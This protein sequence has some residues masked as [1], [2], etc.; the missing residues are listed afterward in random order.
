MAINKTKILALASSIRNTRQELTDPITGVRISRPDPV[1]NMIATCLAELASEVDAIANP[2]PV[3]TLVDAVGTAI[4]PA[5]VTTYS[6]SGG[7]NLIIEWI[8]PDPS[9]IQYF[10][11]R[12]GADYATADKILKTASTRV[13]L[14]PITVGTT[15]YT[16]KSV[17]SSGTE[18]DNA[19]AISVS[20]TAPTAITLTPSVIDNNVLLYW[21]A[22][23][24]FFDIDYYKVERGIT[25]IG[26]ITGTFTTTFESAAGTY[27]YKV[28]PYDIYGNAGLST[29]TSVLVAEPPD[30][31][32]EDELFDTNLDGT[33]TKVAVDG[34]KLLAPIVA[35]TWTQHYTTNSKANIQGFIDGSFTSWIEPADVAG[36]AT[37]VKTFDF[38]SVVTDMLVTADYSYELLIA[39]N[40]VIVGTQIQVSDDNITYTAASVGTSYFAASVRYV[41]VTLTFTA[42]NNRS[43][44][45]LFNLRGVLET[46]RTTDSGT[47]S[48]QSGDSG[49][50][51]V[52][53]N[54]TFKDITSINATVNHT[55]ERRIIIDFTDAPNPTSFKVLVFDTAGSRATNN[56]YWIARGKT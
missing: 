46:K 2:L 55:V 28:T 36:G 7:K 24:G 44:V 35:E 48:A 23:T 5:D 8:N 6:Y 20:V 9:N 45:R 13:V 40:N 25:E 32:L 33:R 1:G 14:E 52:S 41:K 51:T 39:A 18:S 54:K 4:T 12:Q 27:T 56:I 42:S 3:S 17:N 34:D 26:R 49:G 10:D 19:L 43:L 37:Y 30:Y 31:E 15:A 47:I 22:S 53:F 11:L 16:L 50:T 29:T 21:T 38:G